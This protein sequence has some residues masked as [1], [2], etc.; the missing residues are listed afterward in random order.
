[1]PNKYG[2]GALYGGLHL[3]VQ[4]AACEPPAGFG[5]SSLVVHACNIFLKC[6]RCPA[7][8]SCAAISRLRCQLSTDRWRN[9]CQKWHPGWQHMFWDA[10]RAE[11]LLAARYAWFLPTWHSYPR[12]VHK[13]NTLVHASPDYCPPDTPTCAP[14]TKMTSLGMFATAVQTGKGFGG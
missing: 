7:S 5:P 12:I 14:C 13:G 6:M 8:G 2:T 11:A 10:E 4:E 9:S 1:M 3:N